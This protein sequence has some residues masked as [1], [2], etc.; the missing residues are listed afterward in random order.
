MTVRACLCQACR[1]AACLACMACDRVCRC[2]APLTA[3][4]RFSSASASEAA[5]PRRPCR[6]R[7]GRLLPRR[8][9][10]ASRPHAGG[11]DVVL[12]VEQ[13]TAS[14][15]LETAMP[16]FDDL[17]SFY[18]AVDSAQISVDAQSLT[19]LV[20]RVFDYEGSPLSDSRLGFAT[21]DRAEGKAPQRRVHSVLG[22][23]DGSPEHG[24]IRLHPINVHVAGIPAAKMM[25]VFG[26]ELEDLIRVRTGRGVRVR[27]NDLA[28]RG[29]AGGRGARG[30][31]VGQRGSRR[32]RPHAHG[33][34]RSARTARAPSPDSKAANY[35]WF[36]GGL[37]RFGRLTM[38]DADL[39]LIDADEQ[40]RSIS[41]PRATTTSSSPAIPEHAKRRAPDRDARLRRYLTPS[42][43]RLPAPAAGT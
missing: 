37:I 24:L 15:S 14:S 19:A 4:C 9:R 6:R 3:S 36:H 27:D 10:H 29:V 39:Q 42:D 16:V 7:A 43:G 21:D 26:L 8:F 28:A 33:P 23:C 32:R 18:I 2:L 5:E 1:L 25:S 11:A 40:T 22:R 20:N 35:I 31:G 41:T 30:S 34:R 17:T 13:C 38:S 12:D